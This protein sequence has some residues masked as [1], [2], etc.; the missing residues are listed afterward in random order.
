MSTFWL[1]NIH[2]AIE[3]FAAVVLVVAAWLSFDA[4]ALTREKKSLLKVFGFGAFAS[5]QVLHALDITDEV[6][7]L[8]GMALLL[9]GLF[10]IALSIYLEAPPPR[11]KS[12]EL[13]FFIPSVAGFFG[14]F[15]ILA[16]ILALATS[17]VSAR[18]YVKELN[19]PLKSLWIVFL[20]LALS[21]FAGSVGS[22][23]LAPDAW[24]MVEHAV[25][26]AAIMALTVWV[27]QYLRLRMKEELLLIF[28][29]MSLTVSLVVTFTFSALLLARMRADAMVSLQAN[30]R[31]FS[32]T[33][34]SLAGEMEARSLLGAG[35]AVLQRA[36]VEK[37][38]G[39]LEERVK[40][41]R[42]TLGVDF[43]TIGDTDGAVLQ[44]ATYRWT[45]ADTTSQDPV[46]ARAMTGKSSG[47]VGVLAPEGLSVR[48]AAPIYDADGHI[49][50]VLEV[51]RLLDTVFLD[52]F[53]IVTGL[54]ATVFAG[55]TLH[56][57]TILDVDGVTRPGGV[58]LTDAG[59][60]AKVLQMKQAY[61]GSAVFLGKPHLASYYPIK[62]TE[63][64]PIGI[65]A[66]SRPEVEIS[67]AAVATNR[68]TLFTTLLIVLA[69]L[70]PAYLVVKRIS[71][72]A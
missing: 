41:L 59:V 18:R 64:K 13:V 24:W 1:N 7:L 61:T 39:A 21:F 60:L 45:R 44:K 20:L 19:K 43:V 42:S 10:C 51:G 14:R 56:A 12:F 54:D 72:E 71:D 4:Y 70:I 27:W 3:F 58:K 53:K 32:Y 40:A 47:D 2:F 66:A 37:N 67:K 35:D 62:D 46:A 28:V 25:R 17:W 69:L 63:G 48:G 15:Y 23:S 5:W 29:A 16:G 30:A 38:F 65:I 33:V 8:F 6:T 11:P 57:S 9:C 22:R 36:I 49:I 52:G 50:G 34:R 26:T 68:L 31:V 55:D